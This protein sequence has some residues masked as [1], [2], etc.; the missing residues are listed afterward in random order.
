MDRDRL[1]GLVVI[2]ALMIVYF[3]FIAPRQAARRAL[4][5]GATNAAVA[6]ATAP[7]RA[8]APV[9]GAPGAVQAESP[10]PAVGAPPRDE[11]QLAPLSND[12]V[13]FTFANY[14]ASISAIELARTPIVRKGPIVTACAESNNWEMPLRLRRLGA[15]DHTGAVLAV[16]SAGASALSYTGVVADGVMLRAA[17]VLTNEYFLHAEMTFS[18]L[19]S[20]AYADTNTCAFWL[21][22]IN[23]VG[24]A[25]DRYDIPGVD[26]SVAGRN[27]KP[28]VQ[29]VKPEKKD[30]AKV[31]DGP[32]EWLAV[33]NKYFT[34]ILVPDEPALAASV[35]SCGPAGDRQVT[36]SAAFVMPPMPPGAAFHWRATLYAGPKAF[37]QLDTLAARIGR[38]QGYIEILNLGWFSILAK[39][40]LIYGLKGLYRYVHNYGIAIIILT[41]IIKLLTWPLQTKS[42]ESMQRMQKLQPELKE[43]QAKYKSDPRKLQQEQMLLYRKHGVN[44]LGGCLPVALQIPVFIALYA[45]LSN[46]IEL[47]GASFWWIKDLSLPDTVAHLPFSIPFMG[48][49]VN[50]LPL[51]MTVATIGQQILTPHTGDKSQKQ[52]MYMMPIIFLAI[53][54]N[55][56]SGLVLYWFVNQIL[57]AGQM[58]YL[59]Y[60]RKV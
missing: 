37:E 28:A 24:A 32:V 26:V 60:F 39:P 8:P 31:I 35:Y 5:G 56:P 12:C 16:E 33:R 9:I 54:Y 22:R 55:M 46:A 40:I 27:G 15:H 52:M 34:H 23:H 25:G 7:A 18:N 30:S 50:P 29:R 17:Y 49:G 1:T 48:D 42:F 14:D 43:L 19:S 51:L 59:H 44:P 21:G 20:T 4:G 53:F 2:A 41:V 45:A 57:S 58:L 6:A 11:L 13:T 38:G 10:M 47:W 36:A 3:Q